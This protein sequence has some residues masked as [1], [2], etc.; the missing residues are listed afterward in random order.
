[1]VWSQTNP[2][3]TYCDSSLPSQTTWSFSVAMQNCRR[4]LLAALCKLWPTEVQSL[5]SRIHQYNPWKNIVPTNW[6]LQK[7]MHYWVML[8]WVRLFILPANL[9]A[10]IPSKQNFPSFFIVAIFYLFSYYLLIRI[11]TNRK[12]VIM[13]RCEISNVVNNHQNIDTANL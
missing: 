9:H 12:S 5:Q 7:S 8:F 4:A 11:T 2:W 10:T 13:L 6:P 3:I 1:M